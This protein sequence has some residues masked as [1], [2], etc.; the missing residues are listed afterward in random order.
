MKNL[1]ENKIYKTKLC[2]YFKKD[3]ICNKMIN[4][5]LLWHRRIKMFI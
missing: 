2:N 5:F 4:V 1:K 3:G